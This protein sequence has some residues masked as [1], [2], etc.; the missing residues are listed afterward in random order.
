MRSKKKKNP[1]SAKL[2]ACVCGA[3]GQACQHN[4]AFSNGADYQKIARTT[5]TCPM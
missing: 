1:V 4:V 3:A 2:H 5:H